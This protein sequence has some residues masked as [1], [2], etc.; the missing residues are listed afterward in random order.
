[1]TL[2]DCF[3]YYNEADA[4]EWRL[5][6][7]YPVVDA[8]VL[9]E[10]DRTHKGDKKPLFYGENRQRFAR[11][12]DKIREVTIADLPKGDSQAAIWRREIGQRQ[13]ILRGVV[14]LP[15]D[16][17]VLVSDLD[18]I[19]RREIIAAL[20][21]QGMDDAAIYTFEQTL[22]YYNFNTAC[23]NIRWNGTRA[24]Q[25]GNVRA[26][27]P[28]GV[29]WEGLRPRSTEYPIHMR[30]PNAGWHVSYFGDVAH[31]QQKMRAF[32]HQELVSD[33]HLDP[34]TIARRMSQGLDI[35]GREQ[36]QQF[37]IGAAPDLPWAVRSNPAQWLPYFH[38]DWRP[39]FHEDWMSAEQAAYVGGLAQQAPREGAC[40]EVGSWEGR[41]A[42]CIAQS[43]Q[44]RI[45]HCVDHWEG[46]EE[47]ESVKV[48][49]DRDIRGAFLH[50]TRVLTTGNCLV[51]PLDWR[52]WISAWDT[53]IAFLHLDAS[54]DYQSVR[55]C[56]TAVLPFLVP[57]A[58]LCGDDFYHSA[59][60]RA[61]RDVLGDVHDVGG[62]LWVWQNQLQDEG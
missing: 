56:L 62:R 1:M 8:F 11:W 12:F 48:A 14:D 4:L 47:E 5:T 30:V 43:I 40:V 18:E 7:L 59:V 22:Y 46:N 23:H 10:A 3:T 36:A 17:I 33:E 58:I 57:G 21:E 38:P 60:N 50:N 27:T 34:D 51:H 13:A 20:R 61:V 44:P 29:R 42:I 39:V 55:D 19:P 26:L 6:E 49:Q 16:T 31:I 53:P 45:L 15:D 41:S 9:V 35:W 37:S 25:L 52:V 28:D 54:H 24:T 32:L 2:V